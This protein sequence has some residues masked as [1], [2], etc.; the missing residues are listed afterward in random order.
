MDGLGAGAVLEDEQEA[1]Q[2]SGVTLVDGQKACTLGVCPEDCNVDGGLRFMVD[3]LCVVRFLLEQ[4][5]LSVH[6]GHVL[7]HLANESSLPNNVQ[8]EQGKHF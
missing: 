8:I 3:Q 5:G 4:L 7:V 6:S 1:G 2:I